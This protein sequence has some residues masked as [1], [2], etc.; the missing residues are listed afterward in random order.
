[1]INA[2]I[3]DLSLC[4]GHINIP[5]DS[6]LST[7]L[8]NIYMNE[9]DKFMIKLATNVFKR[10]NKLTPEAIKE[11]NMLVRE[12]STRRV[13]YTVSQYGSVDAMKSAFQTKKKAYYIK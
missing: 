12:F 9:L 5:Q 11:Y 2:G 7:L 3:L 4:F 10:A 6:V 1:M 8:F 13:A